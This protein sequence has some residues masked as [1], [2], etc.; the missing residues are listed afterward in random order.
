MFIEHN[1]ETLTMQPKQ[2]SV[3][4][5]SH[6]RFDSTESMIIMIIQGIKYHNSYPHPLPTS[7]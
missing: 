3:V 4:A 5:F 6:T 2:P 7:W 1:S